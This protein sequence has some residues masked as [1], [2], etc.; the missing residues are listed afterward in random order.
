[1]LPSPA[2]SCCIIQECIIPPLNHLRLFPI[3]NRHWLQYNVRWCK[4]VNAIV[5]FSA[6]DYL[7]YGNGLSKQTNMYV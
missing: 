3:V 4:Q 7:D 1:M 6:V 5:T 2:D